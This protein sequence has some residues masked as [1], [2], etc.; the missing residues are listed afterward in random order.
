[1]S[2][3]QYRSFNLV[4][5]L[6]GKNIYLRTRD[7]NLAGRTEFGRETSFSDCFAEISTL[8]RTEKHSK[9]VENIEK[10]E[11]KHEKNEVS[12]PNYYNS[13]LQTIF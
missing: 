9:N 13:L 12:Q 6:D 10:V 5:A 8:H 2:T 11:T 4:W 1:M 3:E 7:L